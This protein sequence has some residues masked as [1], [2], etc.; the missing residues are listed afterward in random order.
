MPFLFFFSYI[1]FA[2]LVN[3]TAFSLRSPLPLGN[4]FFPQSCLFYHQISV[5][6]NETTSPWPMKR[7]HA[8]THIHSTCTKCVKPTM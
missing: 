2:A 3:G 7:G 6:G 5:A 1:H 8:H 4:T